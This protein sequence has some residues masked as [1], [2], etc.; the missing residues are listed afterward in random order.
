M[1]VFFFSDGIQHVHYHSRSEDL[2]PDK[3]QYAPPPKTTKARKPSLIR[4][5]VKE[6]WRSCLFIALLKVAFD[7]SQFV[8]PQLLE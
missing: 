7:I 6:F 3:V 5:M 4:A 2:D 8:Q 1:Y